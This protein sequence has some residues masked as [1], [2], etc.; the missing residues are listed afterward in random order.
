MMIG[1]LLVAASCERYGGRHHLI[2]SKEQREAIATQAAERE[3]LSG[4]TTGGIAQMEAQGASSAE[5]EA[6]QFLYAHMP[7]CDL[8]AF[9]LSYVQQQAQIALEARSAFKWGKKIPNDLFLHYV[10]PFRVANE[11]PDEARVVLYN[12]LKDIAA[13]HS[14]MGDAALEVAHWCREQ[15]GP[16]EAT[17]PRTSG[18]QTVMR[19]AQGHQREMAV[20][21]VSALRAVS[22]PARA[23]DGGSSAWAE[24]WA[25]GQ[26]Y[27]IDMGAPALAL[28]SA[29]EHRSASAQTIVPG[30][31]TGPEAQLARSPYHTELNLL[32]QREGTRTL[33]VKVLGADGRAA[34]GAHV[35]LQQLCN[36][37]L[38]AVASGSTD[39]QGVATL[40]AGSAGDL[41]LWASLGQQYGLQKV[42]ASQQG[43]LSLQLGIVSELPQGSIAMAMRAAPTASSD[44]RTQQDDALR[45]QRVA[46]YIDSTAASELAH[47]KGVKPHSVCRALRLSRGNWEEVQQFVSTLDGKDLTVGM[48]LL[49]GLDERDLQC[50][51]A[52]ML[53]SHLAAVDIFPPL[54][55]VEQYSIFDRYVLAPRIGHEP[56][57]AWREP[58]H[59]HLS[60]DEAGFFRN[61]PELVAHWLREHVSI[62]NKANYAGIPMS[63]LA[64]LRLGVADEQ[65][66][67]IL[68]VAI[69]RSFGIPSRLNPSNQAPQYMDRKGWHT[70][71]A[72]S[73]VSDGQG[74][75]RIK[76]TAPASSQHQCSLSRLNGD[77]S[78]EPVVCPPLPAQ[79]EVEPGV[80]R[81][82]T[83][84][85]QHEVCGLSFV[86]VPSGGSVEVAPNL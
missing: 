16:S 21:L 77:G 58:I 6:V 23:V 45:A 56:L 82:V 75:G 44:Q 64:A 59:Q 4:L 62:D 46:S 52:A 71:F 48:A 54:V 86:E 70:A 47:A 28:R 53:R 31:Y 76:L 84:H 32:P 65:S 14:A 33:K 61:N 68:F 72:L 79:L 74:V 78:F 73:S 60:Y 39:G 12:D 67:D 57:E 83:R 19:A 18:P 13:Q 50:A 80:Y 38:I 63:P 30:P 2:K 41:L 49:D 3:S 8:G 27:A 22:I 51:S 40:Q 15:A 35:E 37:G 10:L 7:L 1:A 26:W 24:A 85:P 5:V 11:Q 81:V 20:L 66:R 55:P 25:D 29:N 42:G 69:C 9:P 34:V 17:C 43:D 36:A